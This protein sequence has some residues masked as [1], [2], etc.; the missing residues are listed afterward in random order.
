[1]GIGDRLAHNG[2]IKHREFAMASGEMTEDEFI[3][4]LNET[5]VLISSHAAGGAIVYAYMDWRHMGEMPADIFVIAAAVD[6]SCS[7]LCWR[8]NSAKGSAL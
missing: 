4:F 3:R 5:L 1:V 2:A 7:Q 6:V 8:P